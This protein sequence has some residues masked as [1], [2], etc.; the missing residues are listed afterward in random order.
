MLAAQIQAIRASAIAIAAQCDALLAALASA[1]GPPP[2]AGDC[3]HPSELRTPVARM[4]AP[5]AWVCA[6][7]AEGGT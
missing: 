4:G 2:G 1:S 3:R 5:G 6:C 7:G